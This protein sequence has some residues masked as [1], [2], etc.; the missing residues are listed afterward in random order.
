M[1]MTRRT[2]PPDAVSESP[3][4]KFLMGTPRRTRRVCTISHNAFNLN[5]SSATSVS[6]DSFS[7]NSIEALDPLKS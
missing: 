5:A 2:V 7:S 6:V 4:L 3:T 1:G